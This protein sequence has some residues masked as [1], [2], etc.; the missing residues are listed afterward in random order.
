[1]TLLRFL[2]LSVLGAFTTLAACSGDGGTK[3]TPSSAGAS[4]EAGAADSEAG[5]AGSEAGAA[6]SE[7]G[8]GS[9]GLFEA[10]ERAQDL[11]RR[12][13]DHLSAMADAVVETKDAQK[14]FEFV[15]DQ[16]LTYPPSIDGFGNCVSAQ[17]W[18]VRGTLR[19]GAGTP[20]EKAEL[21]VSLYAK[22]GFEAAVVRGTA[23]PTKLD[24]KQVLLRAL[25]R[26]LAPPATPDEA[27]EIR[28]ALG[29]APPTAR[30]MIDPKGKQAKALADSLL[31]LLDP[32]AAV[33]AFDFTLTD[34]PLV[35]VDVGGTVKFANVIDPDAAFGEPG[36]T[37]DPLAAAA[38]DDAPSVLVR[39]EGARADK[40]FERFTLVQNTYAAEDVVGR[41][42]NLNFAPPIATRALVGTLPRNINTFV[43]VLSVAGA[44]LT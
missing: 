10:F 8:A 28:R 14:I 44:A 22:A 12:S 15:R 36:T 24:G 40:P 26:T 18:G 19:G 9:L 17:R 41:R 23:D 31:A 43:P 42:I 6:G 30:E 3:G 2:A 5:A 25:D 21:L 38:A 16:I 32:A 4:G 33:A 7:A 1:M 29:N 37:K 39:L 27:A 34:F 13:P 11:V 20:R 35:R